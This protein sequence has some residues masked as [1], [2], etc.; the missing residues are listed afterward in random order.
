MKKLFGCLVIV[1]LGFS[2]CEGPMGPMG[3]QGRDGR[4]GINGESTQWEIID[5]D[6]LSEHWIP[7]YDDLMGDFF[8]YEFRIP[9]LT[10]FIFDAGAVVCYLVQNINA[11]GRNTVIQ[12]PLPYTYYGEYR[13]SF[14]SENYTYEMRPG[15]INFIVKVSDFDTQVQQPL[16]CTF[17]VVMMW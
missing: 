5:C 6:I 12:T 10:K 4:D 7:A 3:P 15:Y 1:I 17:R 16:N 14:Y 2:A 13:G 11:G 8:E 9:E